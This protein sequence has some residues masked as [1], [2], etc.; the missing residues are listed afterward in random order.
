M[1][2]RS[3]NQNLYQSGVV[4]FLKIVSLLLLFIGIA[5][6]SFP[7]QSDSENQYSDTD[8]QDN[9]DYQE[10]SDYQDEETSY[11]DNDKSYQ[12]SSDVGEDEPKFEFNLIPSSRFNLISPSTISIS[13]KLPLIFFN[14]ISSLSAKKA[15][16]MFDK[17]RLLII[18]TLKS[19]TSPFAM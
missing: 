15:K 11:V 8:D 10:D 3:I 12:E 13:S 7:Q 18:S 17:F 4:T 6:P 9:A 19:F 14:K 16:L 1:N 5:S 2:C